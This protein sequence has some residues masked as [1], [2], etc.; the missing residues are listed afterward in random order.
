MN[1]DYVTYGLRMGSGET[2]EPALPRGEQKPI[3]SDWLKK[4]AV[5]RGGPAL[6]DECRDEIERAISAR[7]RSAFDRWFRRAW[8]RAAARDRRQRRLATARVS[9]S[10]Q[11][12]LGAR[13]S[14]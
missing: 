9:H 5:D 3:M 8:H 1:S 10:G 11:R 13:R 2:P 12:V 7:K 14:K 6:L 4:L